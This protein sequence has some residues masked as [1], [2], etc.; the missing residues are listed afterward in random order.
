MCW[1]KSTVINVT[2]ASAVWL[3]GCASATTKAETRA[4]KQA[5]IQRLTACLERH[6][7]DKIMPAVQ[8]EKLMSQDCEGHKRDVLA[9]YPRNMAGQI[10]QMLAGKAYRVIEAK[11]ESGAATIQ[12]VK[13]VQTALR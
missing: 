10:D 6:A 9:L 8:V 7:N 4:I 13:G 1:F 2:I 3:S 5:T 11:S 12:P